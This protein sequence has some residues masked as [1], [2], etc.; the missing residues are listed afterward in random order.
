MHQT[1]DRIARMLEAHTASEEMQWVHQQDVNRSGS[2]R[3]TSQTLLSLLPVLQSTSRRSQPPLEL[4]KVLSDSAK[5]FSTAPQSTSSY[6][7]A[8][9][10]L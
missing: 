8:F 5:E 7:G 9:R 3:Q 1:I 10:M 2:H 4:C 6:G